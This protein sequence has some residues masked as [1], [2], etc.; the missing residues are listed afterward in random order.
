MNEFD[1]I[2][3][4]YGQP[5]YK[6]VLK[7][8]GNE[9]IAEEIVQETFYKAIKKSD[10]FKGDCNILTWLC[11]I[12]KNEYLNYIKRKDN[13]HEN[14]EETE[15]KAEEKN[16]ETMFVDR[17]TAKDVYKIV[18]TLSE[19]QREIF[20]LRIMGDL[21]FREIG[22]ILDCSE[23]NARIIFFRARK[24]IIGIMEARN[25]EM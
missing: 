17:E 8:C 23:N 11:K 4:N 10:N 15:Q 9:F 16:F 5:L 22:E 14:I 21:S 2:Y 25:Y 3:K 6:Y 7:L 18:H 1:E 24:K 12:A 20:M 13:I 19:E